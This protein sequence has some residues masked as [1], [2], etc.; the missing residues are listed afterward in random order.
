M[1][2]GGVGNFNAGQVQQYL[3]N[4]SFPASKEEVVSS[5]QSTGAPHEL[6]EQIRN[7]PTE[8]FNSP[9]EVLNYLP[10]EWTTGGPGDL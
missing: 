5:A 7:A 4:V 6:V 9:D 1:N 2:M 10:G 8:Y 3:A